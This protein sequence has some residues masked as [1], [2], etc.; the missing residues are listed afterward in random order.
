MDL[1]DLACLAVILLAVV[2]GYRR[3]L[4]L[5]GLTAIG[6]LGGLAGGAVLAALVPPHLPALSPTARSVVAIALLLG[7]ALVG[8]AAGAGLGVRL[9][10]SALRTRLGRLDS[11]LGAGFGAAATLLVV[12]FLG[13]TF[14]TG[15]IPQLSAAI[16]RSVV[17]RTLDAH[18]PR[19]AGV[20][21]S[22]QQL[23][24]AV[25]FPEVFVNLVPPL[26]GPVPAPR[27]LA[28]L[29]GVVRAA[30]V[31]VRVVSSGCGGVD[32][33]SGFPIAG[34][35]ILTNAH[36]VAGASQVVVQPPGGRS[37]AATV[38]V[39]DPLRD[40]ALLRA[41]GLHLDA[42]RFGSAG[43]RGATGAVVGY[44]GGGAERVVAAAS[45]GT[46]DAVGRDIYAQA[47][48][49]RPIEVLDADIRPGNSGGP[50]LARDG[51]VI[52]V[53]F[54]KSTVTPGLGFALTPAEVRPDVHRA[55]RRRRAV[56]TE[57]CVA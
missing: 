44:P 54:A 48:V 24:A 6:F 35:L 39:F 42:L 27:D 25:P 22:L 43:G 52:G 53:V 15:P 8:N 17:I 5:G 23:L 11:W 7:G 37:V 47:I 29:P 12:W 2:S 46:L 57:G 21:A 20:F 36:V 33:G 40:V 49:T 9:R 3:G 4:T 18:V 30:A 14:S 50:F 51:R 38:V 32:E 28:G 16:Q 26:P 1:L 34:G 19:P 10:R 56:S 31:T 41:A 55:V 45:R 13:L